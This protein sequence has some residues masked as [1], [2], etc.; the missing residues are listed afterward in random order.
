[1]AQ[2]VASPEARRVFQT[3]SAE[4]CAGAAAHGMDLGEDAKAHAVLSR[5]VGSV[6]RL[7][8]DFEKG[9]PMEVEAFAGDMVR[10]GKEKG[11]AVTGFERGYG[12]L[13]ALVGG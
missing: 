4:G 9:L 12:A 11:V 7:R 6:S 5:S 3:L 13:L 10:L 1:V 8:E 2:I